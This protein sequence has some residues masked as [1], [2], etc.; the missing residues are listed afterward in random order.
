MPPTN[1]T[2]N[3]SS[4]SHSKSKVEDSTGLDKTTI[5]IISAVGGFL[6]LTVLV[7]I[8]LCYCKRKRR[9]R[10]ERRKKET[11]LSV[12]RGDVSINSALFDTGQENPGLQISNQ[13]TR[14]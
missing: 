1:V 2:T 10:Q 14:N 12:V 8:V 11:R 7:I 3:S 13:G 5:I 6:V 4:P 9:Q